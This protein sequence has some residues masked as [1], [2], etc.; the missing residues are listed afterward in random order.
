ML[1]WAREHGQIAAFGVESIGSYA[2]GLARF[3]TDHG[4]QVREVNTPHA[5]IRARIGKNDAIDAGASA[6]K[7]ARW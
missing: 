4:A 2:A 7:S 1:S 5:H 6:R 3:L